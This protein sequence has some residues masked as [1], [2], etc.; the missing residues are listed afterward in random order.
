VKM[1]LYT[2]AAFMMVMAICNLLALGSRIW[3]FAFG[4]ILT[5][6]FAFSIWKKNIIVAEVSRFFQWYKA[7]YYLSLILAITA[8]VLFIL[9]WFLVRK[10]S[11]IKKQE[12]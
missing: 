8:V 11:F 1:V 9:G 10:I 3:T 4:A 7:P 6:L 5:I 2:F 12:I